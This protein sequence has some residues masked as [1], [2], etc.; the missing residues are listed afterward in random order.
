MGWC[1]YS[2]L[3]AVAGWVRAAA[4]AGM[5]A[6]AL[7]STMMA[8]MASSTSGEMTGTGSMA[9]WVANKLQAERPAAMPE[10]RSLAR[11][12]MRSAPWV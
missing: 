12:S 3:S 9:T 2:V 11:L 6:T 8:G 7:A 5:A 4:R 1:G 10:L